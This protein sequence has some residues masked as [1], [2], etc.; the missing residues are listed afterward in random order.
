MELHRL[1]KK[2]LPGDREELKAEI[3]KLFA[4]AEVQ[5]EVI[6]VGDVVD[7][8]GCDCGQNDECIVM[9]RDNSISALQN[10]VERTCVCSRHS[11][12][13]TLIRKGPKKYEVMAESFGNGVVRWEGA[14]ILPKG[15][16]K[17]VFEEKSQ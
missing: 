12:N 11:S 2:M 10:A 17:A 15:D 1:V 5:D 6:E 16:Y 3:L 4:E 7:V 9:G 8:D 14:C 13:L